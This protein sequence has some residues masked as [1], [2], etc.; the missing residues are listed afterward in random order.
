MFC[1]IQ[2][3]NPVRK[4]LENTDDLVYSSWVN[5]TLLTIIVAF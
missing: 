3:A 4:Y 2:F 5:L 1:E